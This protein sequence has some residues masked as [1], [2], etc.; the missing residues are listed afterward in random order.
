[1]NSTEIEKKSGSSLEFEKYRYYQCVQNI[2]G[3]Y[4]CEQMYYNDDY[5]KNSK[6]LFVNSKF[7]ICLDGFLLKYDLIPRVVTNRKYKNT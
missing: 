7:P 1:M 6:L 5:I 3:D 4:N 2:F